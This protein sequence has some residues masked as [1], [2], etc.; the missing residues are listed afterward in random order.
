MDQKTLSS[1]MYRLGL[2]FRDM[3]LRKGIFKARA[4][5]CTI[6]FTIDALV[7]SD[8]TIQKHAFPLAC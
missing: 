3:Q 1:T 5:T 6:P 4:D 7:D 8:E 2:T